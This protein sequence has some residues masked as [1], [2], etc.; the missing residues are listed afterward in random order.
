MKVLTVIWSGLLT[1][2]IGF[3]VSLGTQIQASLAAWAGWTFGPLVAFWMVYFA[4]KWVMQGAKT[5]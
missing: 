2:W 3:L 4:A 5:G 1:A